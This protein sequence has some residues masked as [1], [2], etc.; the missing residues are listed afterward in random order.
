[1]TVELARET[2]PEVVRDDAWRVAQEALD[3]HAV[4][5]REA[6]ATHRG[7]SEYLM[8][9]RISGK[10]HLTVVEMVNAPWSI[11]GSMTVGNAPGPTLHLGAAD[12]SGFSKIA[13]H[14][15]LRFYR[16]SQLT[17]DLFDAFRNA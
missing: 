10:Q 3:I 1:M 17:D 6:L 14:P 8:W 4:L 11:S 12:P 9:F 5:H 7:D 2:P 16:L 15:A 13:H